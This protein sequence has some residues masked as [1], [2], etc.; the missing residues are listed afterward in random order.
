MFRLLA[1][2]IGLI[3]G[4]LVVAAFLL[5]TQTGN[6]L[7]QPLAEQALAHKLPQANITLLDIR[8]DHANLSIQLSP[9]TQV[10][11][12]A[13]TN[14]LAAS[15]IGTWQLVSKDLTQLQGMT[16]TPL[17][18][19]ASSEGNFDLSPAQQQ[20]TGKL[21]LSLSQIDFTLNHPKDA[22]LSIDAQG[23]LL[24]TEVAEL[25]Q[26]PDM[27]TGHL[28]LMTQLKLDKPRDLQTLNGSINTNINDGVLVAQNIQ[29]ATGVALPNNTPF[30]FNTSTDILDGKTLTQS[31]F[32]SPLLTT[33]LNNLRYNIGD[34]GL[35]SDHQT[36]ISDLSKLAFLTGTPL[37]GRLQVDG[38]LSY[39]LPTHHLTVNANSQTLG[40]KVTTKL[41]GNQLIA[42][43]TDLQTT[44][45]SVMLDMPVVFKS[46]L[47]GDVVYD[48]STQQ[49]KFDTN[50]YNGQIL[51]NEM[52]VLLNSAAKFDITREVYEQVHLDGSINT[53]V[54]TS[55]LDMQSHLT[56][57][58][59]KRAEVN[60]KQHSVNAI[61]LAQLQGFTIPVHIQGDLTHPAV[62]SDLGNLLNKQ[63]EKA[64]AESL[65]KEKQNLIDKL[66]QQVNLPN[67]G[68]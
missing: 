22:P 57:L 67:F 48:L 61:L 66:K 9:D 1:W 18:G 6:G 63:A 13:Q 47:K 37:H 28:Q 19:A 59:A 58:T 60:L 5:F 40:G 32:N 50:L 41:N 52:S 29:Q 8:P 55:N 10:L 43:F 25:L 30:A 14:L 34:D 21:M 44:E 56:H 20:V 64:A 38:N 46:S 51:P 35:V 39:T 54:I 11:L 24:L 26:Q 53:G 27:A 36:L 4:T 12:N 33:G 42:Q 15:A 7:L 16:H 62:S 68:R 31:L 3:V 49:G 2:I 65:N 23:K 17:A 45:L